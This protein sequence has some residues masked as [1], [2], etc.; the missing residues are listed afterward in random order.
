MIVVLGEAIRDV[1]AY[2]NQCCSAE[3]PARIAK[4]PF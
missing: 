2:P 4:C 1:Q 3:T